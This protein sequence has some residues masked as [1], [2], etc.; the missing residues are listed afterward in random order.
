MQLRDLPVP[1]GRS[2]PASLRVHPRIPR[3]PCPIPSLH[4]FPWNPAGAHKPVFI[5][6][7]AR[8]V[9]QLGVHFLHRPLAL[10]GAAI[11]SL[12][13]TAASQ[14]HTRGRGCHMTR[15]VP[16]AH[17]APTL[18]LTCSAPESILAAATPN[19][20]RYYVKGANPTAPMGTCICS[21]VTTP[22]HTHG[23]HEPKPT[24]LQR[25]GV[26]R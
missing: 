14:P 22:R 24:T 3:H 16:E 13:T 12:R 19:T 21:T 11:L 15:A 9:H 5:G 6:N 17:Q 18:R 25:N 7:P 1:R 26:P 23:W 8:S 4:P 20:T 2:P 10:P